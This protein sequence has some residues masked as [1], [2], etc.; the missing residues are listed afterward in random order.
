MADAV[1]RALFAQGVQTMVL[2]GDNVRRGLNCDLGFSDADRAENIRRVAEAAKLLN[3][4]GVVVLT[5][6]ISPFESDRANARRIIGDSFVEVYVSTSLQECERR[7]VKGLYQKAR[8]GE[9]R[10][11]TGISSPYEAPSNPDVIVDTAGKAV[12]ESVR[13]VLEE[14]QPY[15]V[16]A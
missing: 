13:F 3:D 10:E 2:D 8:R 1:E 14:L 11:F 6:F 16:L 5:A 9:I 12:E 15:L 4:A 7:D